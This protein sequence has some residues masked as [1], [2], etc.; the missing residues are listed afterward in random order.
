VD[1]GWRWDQVAGAGRENLDPGHVARYNRIEDAGAL[2]E[3]EL[4]R[5][6]GLG[7]GCRVVEIGTG[8]GQFAIA[9]ARAGADVVAVDV[10]PPMLASLRET[11][12]REAVDGVEVVEAGFLDYE[13]AGRPADVVYTRYALHH[14]PDFWKGVALA[15][16]CA[17]LRPGGVLRVWDVV[18]G[19][20]P[21]EAEAR[22]EAW[23][24]TGGPDSADA[25]SR[26]DYEE[27]VRDEH[28]TYTWVFEALADHA[29]LVLE[30]A[31]YSEDRI[32]ARYLFRRP[33]PVDD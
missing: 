30:E 33:T 4:L 22:L 16:M 6:H 5:R 11:L 1:A 21:A 31:E 9:A 3:V 7:S 15:R 19:F 32:F 20:E 17:L 2:A 10:S 26:A 28:S 8:T 29:G 24:A 23:C 18:Y 27:H 12:E 13:H 14:L 25:W